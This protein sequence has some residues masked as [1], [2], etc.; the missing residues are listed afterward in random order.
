MA[1]AVETELVF[2]SRDWFE[3]KKEDIRTLAPSPDFGVS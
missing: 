1:I 3:G 2:S